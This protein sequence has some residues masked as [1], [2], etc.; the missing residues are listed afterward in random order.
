LRDAERFAG[1]SRHG[2]GIFHAPASG[3]AVGISAVYDNRPATAR[4]DPIFRK[5]YGSG[6]HPVSGKD[7]GGRGT[8]FCVNDPK[9]RLTRL[10]DPGADSSCA[11]STDH[12][13][14]PFLELNQNHC[15]G[16]YKY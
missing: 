13:L 12:R 7:R 11:K 16:S 1:G 2:F 10:L 5:K 14:H 8:L 9:I 4:L 6:L 15:S 3:A